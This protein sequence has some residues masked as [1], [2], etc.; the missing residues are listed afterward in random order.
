MVDLVK[1]YADVIEYYILSG[2]ASVLCWVLS[3]V[4]WIISPGLRG[5][6]GLSTLK[7]QPHRCNVIQF[8][9]RAQHDTKRKKALST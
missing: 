6:P 4:L 5:A 2:F 1:Y 9:S 8:P 7:V 3:A